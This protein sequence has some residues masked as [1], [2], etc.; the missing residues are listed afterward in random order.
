M[1]VMGKRITIPCAIEQNDI[2]SWEDED[3]VLYAMEDVYI[4]EDSMLKIK[5][6]TSRAQHLFQSD[7][8][9]IS[10]LQATVEED[11]DYEEWDDGEGGTERVSTV[12]T[13]GCYPVTETED[14]DAL[15][16]CGGIAVNP[17]WST[18]ISEPNVEHRDGQVIHTSSSVCVSGNNDP[19]RTAG[20]TVRTKDGERRGRRGRTGRSPGGNGQGGTKSAA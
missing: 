17:M 15:A 11:S 14:N 2:E 13:E 16:I 7:I 5:A 1:E 19:E 20:G 10:E 3:Q 6:R 12:E 9:E 18:E 8:Y 4:P